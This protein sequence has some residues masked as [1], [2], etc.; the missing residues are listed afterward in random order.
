M[1]P[2]HVG[3]ILRM[4]S[5]F[6]KKIPRQGGFRGLGVV[7]LTFLRHIMSMVIDDL[8]VLYLRL[9]EFDAVVFV[10]HDFIIDTLFSLEIIMAVEFDD[11]VVVDYHNLVG[12]HGCGQ[13][14]GDDY[15]GCIRQ[16][17]FEIRPEDLFGM[18][19]HSRCA[20]VQEQ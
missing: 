15:Y 16:I 20:V 11:P 18:S 5:V 13:P 8:Y 4:S 12:L 10:C 3:E 2:C 19:I 9:F 17:F 1:P 7:S 14:M 6:S